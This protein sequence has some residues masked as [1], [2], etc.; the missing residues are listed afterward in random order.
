VNTQIDLDLLTESQEPESKSF[1]GAQHYTN[2]KKSLPVLKDFYESK[3]WNI[4]SNLGFLQ[5]YTKPAE[6][7]NSI[8]ILGRCEINHKISDIGAEITRQNIFIEEDSNIE[9]TEV[10][11]NVG[12]D[13]N[14]H[15]IKFKKFL[16][17][18]VSDCVIL[19]QKIENPEGASDSSIVFPIMSVNHYKKKAQEGVERLHIEIGGWVLKS[20]GA[21]KTLV[22]LFFNVKFPDSEVPELILSKHVKVVI[23]MLRTLESLCNKT[24]FNYRFGSKIFEKTQTIILDEN[25]QSKSIYAKDEEEDAEFVEENKEES[26]DEDDSNSNCIRVKYPKDV[27]DIDPETLDERQREFIIGTRSKLRDLINLVN[28]RDW[29]QISDKKKTK[30]FVRKGETGLTCVKGETYFPFDAEKI[31]EY[32]KRADIRKHYDKHTD[33]AH[34]IEEMPYRTMTVY[35]KTKQILVVAA[36]DVTFT[37]Q[38]ITSK[39][40]GCMYTPTYSIELP[41]YPAE[42]SPVRAFLKLGGWVLKSMPDGGCECVYVSE[43]DLQGNIPQFLVEKTADI[44][45]SVVT[46]LK[47][48][49]MKCENIKEGEVWKRPPGEEV[50]FEEMPPPPAK[51]VIEETKQPKT[52][53]Q[54]SNGAAINN[55]TMMSTDTEKLKDSSI[56]TSEVKEEQKKE[57]KKVAPIQKFKVNINR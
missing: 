46:E 20:L 47:K 50:V 44:Q 24:F 25:Y 22:N 35:A 38:L 4:L 26:D 12:E 34:I 56:T 14:V 40:T 33:T 19:C 7:E 10:L 54:A 49:M 27:Y 55:S 39:E 41:E 11:Q 5:L 2:I 31:I 28:K 36:R 42:K 23:N 1:F 16:V 48:Y 29:K 9:S 51:K 18:E 45:V 6:D 13:I 17:S 52:L 37:S 43:M 32:V 53:R 21:K 8:H 3:E 15:H 30:I 57:E